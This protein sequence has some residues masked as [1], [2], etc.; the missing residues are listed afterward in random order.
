MQMRPSLTPR[1]T[2]ND[3]TWRRLMT[4][5]DAADAALPDVDDVIID[6]TFRA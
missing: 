3:N 5:T 2:R 6:V 1:V 4:H